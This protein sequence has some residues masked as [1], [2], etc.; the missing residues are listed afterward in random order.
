VTEA[1]NL[2]AVLLDVHLAA[3][4][5]DRPALRYQGAT[6]SYR[7]V[8]R[9]VARAGGALRRSAWRSRPGRAAAPGFAGV[10]RDVSSAQSASV[11][12]P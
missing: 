10:R 12:Y 11:P 6:L 7:D 9:L 8:S 3:G 4:R 5:G 2:S 1:F